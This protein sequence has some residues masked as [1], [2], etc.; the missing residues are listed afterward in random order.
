M[1]L[2]LDATEMGFVEL[3]AVPDKIP[4]YEKFGFEANE[5]QRLK[6]YHHVE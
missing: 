6:I 2:S 3:C 5:A 1:G 4:F